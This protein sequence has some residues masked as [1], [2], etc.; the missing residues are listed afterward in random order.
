MCVMSTDN[1]VS[2]EWRS[3]INFDTL[4]NFGVHRK[5]LTSY[6]IITIHNTYK[7]HST[8][9]VQVLWH[10]IFSWP[11]EQKLVRGSMFMSNITE[12]Q[13]HRKCD[14]V[15][16]NVLADGLNHASEWTCFDG[17]SLLNYVNN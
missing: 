4:I 2:D 7:M 6:N 12:V 11:H 13:I 9:V 3:N 14:K 10:M 17:P 15:A 1:D 16:K 5:K 8:R